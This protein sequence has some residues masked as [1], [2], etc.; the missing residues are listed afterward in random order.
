[1]VHFEDM[2]CE[3]CGK[4]FRLIWKTYPDNW[5]EKRKSSYECPYCGKTYFVFLRGNEDVDTRKISK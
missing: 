3:D 2:H 1:M 4:E 5:D